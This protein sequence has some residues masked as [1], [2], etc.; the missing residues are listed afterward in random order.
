M[1]AGIKLVS[2][3]LLC[4]Q[5]VGAQSFLEQFSYEGL[6]F[7]GIGVEFGGVASDRLT[8]EFSGAVRVDYG[9][10]APKVRVLIG[11]SYF[12]GEL[13]ATEIQELALGIQRVVNPA[14]SSL[15][16]IGTITWSDIEVDLDLQ[17][18]LEAGT[19]VTTY[20]GVGFATH[21]RNGSGT[22]IDDTF[23]EDALDTID[24]GLNLSFGTA[25]EV[26]PAMQFTID[27]RGGLTSELRTATARAGFM[28]RV[29]GRG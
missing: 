23:V 19:R 5:I 8:R 2:L 4:P 18:V 26:F 10:I 17:Y 11:A 27:L 22:I 28:Y 16:D 15:I 21:V 7:S 9:R 12:E 25:V 3:L 14:M 6:R 20:V 13:N 29:A 24:A 1:N